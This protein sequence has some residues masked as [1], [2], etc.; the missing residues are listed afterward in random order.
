M[1]VEANYSKKADMYENSLRRRIL[2]Q[3]R[4]ESYSEPRSAYRFLKRHS[5]IL[6]MSVNRGNQPQNKTDSTFKSCSKAIVIG[7][8][9]LCD[10]TDAFSAP[11]S[12]RL[13]H[14]LPPTCRFLLNGSNSLYILCSAGMCS[15]LYGYVARPTTDRKKKE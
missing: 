12:T 6:C 1:L 11:S 7:N 2:D 4:T 9:L 8:G 15:S 3:P 14:R 5:R 13:L 10:T